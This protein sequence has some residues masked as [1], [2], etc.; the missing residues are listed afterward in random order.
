MSFSIV[1]NNLGD[2]VKET[3]KDMDNTKSSIL[4]MRMTPNK[5]YVDEKTETIDFLSKYLRRSLFVETFI[6]KA[7]CWYHTDHNSN[8]DVHHQNKFVSLLS[9]Y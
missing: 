3:D 5:K 7:T 1:P 6:K 2:T 8:S 9:I 4:P